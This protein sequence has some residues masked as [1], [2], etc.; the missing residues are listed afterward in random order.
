MII[1]V[2][3]SLIVLPSSLRSHLRAASKPLLLPNLLPPADACSVIKQLCK[4]EAPHLQ[5]IF[6]DVLPADG[7]PNPHMQL[8]QAEMNAFEDD[9][10]PTRADVDGELHFDAA[11]FDNIIATLTAMPDNVLSPLS[12]MSVAMQSVQQDCQIM[13]GAAPLSPIH[14]QA[15]ISATPPALVA[16]PSPVALPMSPG[17]DLPPL[18]P[19]NTRVPGR[20]SHTATA[21]PPL[22][23]SRTPLHAQGRG[24]SLSSMDSSRR[25]DDSL[26]CAPVYNSPLSSG[27]VHGHTHTS[28]RDS[29]IPSMVLNTAAAAAMGQTWAVLPAAVGR[30]QLQAEDSIQ[31]RHA[32]PAA[33]RS[34]QAS[35]TPGGSFRLFDFDSSACAT[36]SRSQASSS[37]HVQTHPSLEQVFGPRIALPAMPDNKQ[38]GA[39]HNPTALQAKEGSNAGSTDQAVPDAM[40]PLWHTLPTPPSAPGSVREAAPSAGGILSPPF[41]SLAE[42]KITMEPIWAVNSGAMNTTLPLPCSPSADTESSN[43][44]TSETGLS[45]NNPISLRGTANIHP[46]SF[47]HRLLRRFATVHGLGLAMA[48]PSTPGSMSTSASGSASGSGPFLSPHCAAL[49]PY[50]P[51]GTG[52][53]LSPLRPMHTLQDSP[54]HTPS[55]SSSATGMCGAGP[56]VTHARA[57]A[58][59]SGSAAR[60]RS[61]TESCIASP[62]QPYPAS[63]QHSYIRMG[64]MGSRMGS[65][66]ASPVLLQRLHYYTT[67]HTF[68]PFTGSSKGMISAPHSPA[69]SA[70][71]AQGHLLD[72]ALSRSSLYGSS[73]G[74]GGGLRVPGMLST[75]GMSDANPRCSFPGHGSRIQSLSG[76]GHIGHIP[77]PHTYS[78]NICRRD[79]QGS[80][81]SH[82]SVGHVSGSARVPV[83]CMRLHASS[84]GY[85]TSPSVSGSLSHA[86][87][88][89]FTLKDL[90]AAQASIPRLSVTMQV[91]P[92]ASLGMKAYR[93]S[94]AGNSHSHRL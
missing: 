77:S 34:S 4:Q 47:E 56:W 55:L 81:A 40:I 39:D 28:C 50:T 61:G 63:M 25:G 8:F 35:E 45:S 20:A 76:T 75:E 64:S 86:V 57:G 46:G 92:Q 58:T 87:G 6:P 51:G 11:T 71:R 33:A 14:L 49:S 93:H 3:S 89:M 13:H 88:R 18:P 43:G 66:R 41:S 79:S 69:T 16:A 19:I 44:F 37:T 21:L 22:P 65:A 74:D 7:D 62:M 23:P 48:S 85:A 78:S 94:A 38:Y 30:G 53:A 91:M 5:L 1:Q 82:G 2:F 73:Y 9:L 72:M 36:P 67:S 80:Q 29:V 70:A 15:G 83:Q 31:G 54:R 84:T 24:A 68:S 17:P 90:E 52:Y 32:K 10:F 59:D 60:P 42:G 27:V 12:P 26:N